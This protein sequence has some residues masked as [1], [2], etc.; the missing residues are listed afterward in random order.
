MGSSLAV[1]PAQCL[2]TWIAH[3]RQKLQNTDA[4]FID[5]FVYVCLCVL[6]YFTIPLH[7]ANGRQIPV[8]NAMKGDCR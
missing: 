5:A 2:D 4:A 7:S 3:N 6:D 1:F 8:V